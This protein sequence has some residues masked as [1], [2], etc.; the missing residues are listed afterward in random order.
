MV[1]P[2]VTGIVAAL[3]MKL[4]HTKMLHKRIKLFGI[5]IALLASSILFLNVGI[6]HWRRPVLS[7]LKNAQNRSFCHSL[8]VFNVTKRITTAYK[9][10]PDESLHKSSN[11]SDVNDSRTEQNTWTELPYPLD[12]DTVEVVRKL[13]SG[14]YVEYRP[15]F[16]YPYQFTYHHV[17]TQRSSL[18]IFLIKSATK[19]YESR[20]AIRE[21]WANKDLMKKHDFI[22]MFLLG[23]DKSEMYLSAMKSEYD[24]YKDML[25]MSFQDDYFNNTL[26][27]TGAIHW[28]AKHCNRSKFVVFVD[29]D[30]LVSTE[31]LVH[32]LKNKVNL[33]KYFGGFITN[34]R[35][36]R[37]IKS[38]W[39]VSNKDY[40]Y[41]V[42][43]TMPSAGFM[44]M[45]M[46]YVID[47]QFAAQYTKKFIFDDCY[48]GILA[49]KL[50]VSPVHI[51]AVHVRR[52]AVSSSVFKT[53]MI[54]SHSYNPSLLKK[55]WRTLQTF[56]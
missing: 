1:R 45:T 55:T 7:N 2:R 3:P 10:I 8:E 50:H 38:K 32:F 4:M 13:R 11:G 27:T 6:L 37:D 26:K 53:S 43:P 25:L 56:T 49:Y 22:R 54:A 47:L 52:V 31:R 17:C 15:I 51:D 42:Y 19:N 44:V 24:L 21:T 18:F 30:M 9:T 35:P 14:L 46:D 28:T 34:H 23:T 20:M 33:S 40:P 16:P 48:L 36:Y 41:D 39:Y 5:F 29:D 12:I